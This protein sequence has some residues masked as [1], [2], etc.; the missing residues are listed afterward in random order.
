MLHA[1]IEYLSGALG[2]LA[3]VLSPG[4]S[5]LTPK[6]GELFK[7]RA[8]VTVRA[9]IRGRASESF[10][11]TVPKSTTVQVSD[12]HLSASGDALATIHTDGHVAHLPRKHQTKARAHGYL[13]VLPMAVLKKS[14]RPVG[15]S[16]R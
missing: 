7:A 5:S 12:E 3:S 11:T 2:E 14:F 9:Y 1:L 6:P 10:A 16:P 8:Q 4:S 15:A 13:L